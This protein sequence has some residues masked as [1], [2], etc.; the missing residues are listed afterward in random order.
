MM[1]KRLI[2]LVLVLG[3]VISFSV[4][5]ESG[6][7]PKE[8][9]RKAAQP[10]KAP[11]AS[12]WDTV[13]QA[14]KAEGTLIVYSS[15]NPAT[16]QALTKA[17][18]D[19]YGIAV[20]FMVG[21]G[22][23]QIQR[24]ATENRAGLYLGDLMLYGGTT[25]L[26]NLKPT[27]MTASLESALILPEVA[28]PAMWRGKKLPFLDKERQVIAFISQTNGR[29]AVNSDAV[30]PGDIKSYRDIIDPKWKGKI[31]MADPTV[32]GAAEELPL[33]FIVLFGQ[34]KGMEF[35]RQ[36]AKQEPAIIRD[37]R[38]LME[39]LSRNKYAI[40]LGPDLQTFTEFKGNG[41]P[42]T[43]MKLSE[44]VGVTAGGGCLAMLKRAAH[45]NAALVFI[46]WLLSKEGQTIFQKAYGTPSARL[47]V[48][49]TGI[50][51]AFIPQE[52]ERLISNM[53]EEWYATKAHSAEIAR[54]VFKQQMQ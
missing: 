33:F 21:R 13:L 4:T 39:W 25:L 36:I 31:V 7:A 35:L 17:L 26:A 34:E 27:G 41:A 9:P 23:E 37:K 40:A 15:V 10:A 8:Q 30:K 20:D 18:K 48:D 28:D 32:S 53:S 14:A 3:L 43:Y 11:P 2:L 38:L 6:A 51:P 54:Q 5:P 45:P 29:V 12:R 50:D 49:M 22:E 44:G 47:D 1:N 42:I 16:K 24:V 46:N 19:R 52:G